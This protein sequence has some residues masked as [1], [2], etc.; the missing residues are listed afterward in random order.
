MKKANKRN[1]RVCIQGAA[2]VKLHIDFF[3]FIRRF[4]FAVFVWLAESFHSFSLVI[5]VFVYFLVWHYI[6]W[7]FRSVSVFS[8]CHLNLGSEMLCCSC[9]AVLHLNMRAL[10]H[11][12]C[13]LICWNHTFIII[14][15]A[16]T[17]RKS[18]TKP[19]TGDHFI[20]S[21]VRWCFL[22][23][24]FLCAQCVKCEKHLMKLKVCSHQN[25]TT[26]MCISC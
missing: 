8:V 17:K 1:G 25:H 10:F 15:V 4:V 6:R 19:L 2:K 13:I 26:D 12:T 7:Y 21:S 22:L 11:T 20:S 24:L 3:L 18:S 9:C 16:R 23:V 14:F 5:L